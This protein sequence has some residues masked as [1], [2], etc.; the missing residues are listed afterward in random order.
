MSG[1]MRLAVCLMLAVCLLA[2]CGNPGGTSSAPPPDLS[3]EPASS[4]PNVQVDW[5]KL[6]GEASLQPDVDGGRWYPEY[7]DH[8][9]PGEDYG[10]L[11]PYV[12]ACMYRFDQ[13]TNDA[14]EEENWS[15]S[16]PTPLYGLM[17]R[18]GKIVVDPVYTA[19]QRVSVWEEGQ[20]RPL[21]ALMLGQ[22]SPEWQ[23]V[24]SGQRYA[25]AAADGSWI[26]GS[27]FWAYTGRGDDLLL[28]G[29]SGITLVDTATGGRRDWSWESLGIG[30]QELSRF[31][32]D[33]I[34][35]YGLQWTGQGVYLG[36]EEQDTEDWE[37]TQVRIFHPETGEITWTTRA[38][39][40]EWLDA[41]WSGRHTDSEEW[42]WSWGVDG[43]TLTRGQ[44]IRQIP[45]PE[46]DTRLSAMVEGNYVLA[47]GEIQGAS[48]SWLFRLD[49]GE[50]LLQ[51]VS[52][53]FLRDGWDPDRPP[54]LA[55]WDEDGTLTLYVPDEAG[56]FTQMRQFPSPR[57]DNWLY[58]EL[59]DGL[60]LIRDDGTFFGAYDVESGDCVFYRN[61][62]LGE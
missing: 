31:S 61:L 22:A 39:W 27:D 62:D 5:S 14:G 15:D 3:R 45:V 49:T 58:P 44:E 25:A 7:T 60:L 20:E 24:N 46:V 42:S 51:G 19:V 56:G 12:G 52:L 54:L 21:P 28:A 38:Q 2:G 33:L 16:F 23:E 36:A 48:R 11:V 35:M 17:T 18:E 26:T 6:E 32:E 55:G 8:L 9:I 29:D 13:W 1:G 47:D 41:L 10:S 50:L 4:G 53:T 34:W 59:W 57:S 30:S 40:E 37:S 43:L